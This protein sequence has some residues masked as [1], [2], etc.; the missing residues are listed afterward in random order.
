MQNVMTAPSS[1]TPHDL[2]ERRDY[3]TASEVAAVLGISEFKTAYDVWLEKCAEALGIVVEP[4]EPS[5]AMV[6]GTL[7]EQPLLA[8]TELKLRQHL[9][10]PALKV[11]KLGIRRKHA[12]LCMSATLDARIVGRPE[13]I[14]AKTFGSLHPNIDWSTWGSEWSDDIP[15]PY[16]AQVC[17]QLACAPDLARIWVVLSVARTSPAFY[18]VER[19]DHLDLI[20]RIENEVCAFWD[21]HVLTNT[22][23]PGGPT[24]ETIK[25]CFK[26]SQP[27]RVV[28]LEDNQVEQSKALGT[29]LG[30][31][32]K[33]K[34]AIDAAIRAAMLGAERGTT[35]KGH[36][37]TFSHVNVGAHTIEAFSYD[38]MNLRL[39][40]FKSKPGIG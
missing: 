36:S 22:P 23:P 7:M 27:G 24:M 12:N 38:R 40:T 5:D 34:D 29:E 37:V 28:V 32:K 9:T 17:A 14:E 10:D 18:C 1:L 25:R 16:L 3:I 39:V 30:N 20:A 21:K 8:F 6:W 13:A 35:P 15:G 2:L 33:Q 19:K 31:L 4:L 11:T 26:A